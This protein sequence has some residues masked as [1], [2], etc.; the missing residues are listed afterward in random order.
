LLA[1]LRYLGM[2]KVGQ[3]PCVH[4][5]QMKF[6]DS[7][8]WTGTIY[9]TVT[10][11]NRETTLIYIGEIIDETMV[12][13]KQYKSDMDYL[14]IIIQGL[15]HAKEGIINLAQTY[16]SDPAVSARLDVRVM[17]IDIQLRRYKEFLVTEEES[18]AKD[19]ELPTDQ[20]N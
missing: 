4:N 14:P 3:K 13:I 2:I 9:R 16:K 1:K 5:G 7:A 12:S 6:V 8:T 10:G 18:K 15:A 20:Q 11:D 17:D 19:D